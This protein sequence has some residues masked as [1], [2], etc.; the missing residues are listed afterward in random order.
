MSN[1]LYGLVALISFAIAGWL[2]FAKRG[3]ADGSIVPLV[4]AIILIVVG[5][6]FG[7]LFLSGRVNKT[8]D[9]HITE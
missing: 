7:A 8:E 2:F 1:L 3:E 4:I 9:I 5:I 6:I